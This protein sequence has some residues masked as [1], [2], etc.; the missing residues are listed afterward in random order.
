[1]GKIQKVIS[2][3]VM[4]LTKYSNTKAQLVSNPLIDFLGAVAILV[5]GCLGYLIMTWVTGDW[6]W[7]KK[8]AGGI[9]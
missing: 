7:F 4:T 2:A 8:W 5:V 1:M 6:F 3:S 9:L